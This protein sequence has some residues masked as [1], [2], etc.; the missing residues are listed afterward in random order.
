[1]MSI[2]N[3]VVALAIAAATTLVG[4]GAAPQQPSTPSATEPSAQALRQFSESPIDVDYQTASLRTVLRQLAEIGGVNLVLDP[5]VTTEA[6]VDLKLTQVPWY[7]VM[8]VVL[9]SGGLTYELDGPVVRVLT[10]VQQTTERTE[11]N[12]AATEGAKVVVANLPT[13]RFRLSYANAEDVAGLLKQLKYSEADRGAVHFEPRT[14]MLIVQATETDLE[15]IRGLVADLDRPE[16]QVEIEARIVQTTNNT[17]RNIGVRWGS[18]GEASSALGNTTGLAFPNSGSVQTVTNA[19]GTSVGEFVGNND[20]GSVIGLAMGAINGAFNLDV[21]LR[22]LETEGALKVISTPRIT[23]QNNMEAEVTSGVEIPYQVVTTTGGVT[24]TS[25]QFKDAA[26]KLLVTPKITPADTVIM[27]IALEN[28]SP[29]DVLGSEQAGPSIRTDRARTS[30]QV[31]DGATTVIG[32]ILATQDTSDQSRTP[33]LSRVPLL[34]W[35][36]KNTSSSSLAQ[37]LLIFITPRIIR[38]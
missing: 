4:V 27:S 22:A 21:A 19:G 29:S 35:L 2:R 17:E 11:R 23:T 15:Q 3:C 37:E 25:I 31:A 36:F 12:R 34:G 10:I 13:E 33:G 8:D 1:M 5:S 20:E 9:R 6:T 7:Q 38:G 26:L 24:S 28:G 16:P 30:V 32:G 14:N 18:S